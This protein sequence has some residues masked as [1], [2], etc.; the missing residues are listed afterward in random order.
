MHI[1]A[2][3][4]YVLYLQLTIVF[5]AVSFAHHPLLDYLS[6]SLSVYLMYMQICGVNL[7]SSTHNTPVSSIYACGVNLYSSTHNTPVSSM[8]V[9]GV[10]LY[11]LH[12]QYSCVQYVRIWCESVLLHTQ[13]SCVQYIR[14]WCESVPPP[15]TILLCPVCTYMV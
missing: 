11:L 14:M 3:I 15:H 8:Y 1:D 6:R 2:Y 10:N 13:Y 9:Y 5:I 7:Y 12:T 4:Q